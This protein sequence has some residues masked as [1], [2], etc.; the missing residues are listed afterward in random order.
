MAAP[1]LNPLF[2]LSLPNEEPPLHSSVSAQ[3]GNST[4]E[5]VERTGLE[6]RPVDHGGGE[7]T[8]QH[9]DVGQL[10]LRSNRQH[11]SLLKTNGVSSHTS[12]QPRNPIDMTSPLPVTSLLS[13]PSASNSPIDLDGLSWPSMLCIIYTIS[14]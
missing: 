12:E 4:D 10:D 9:L 11:C 3:E 5:A 7:D 1:R 14:N 8:K 2:A 6:K 13:G